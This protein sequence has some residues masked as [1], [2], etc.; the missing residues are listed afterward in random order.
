LRMGAEVTVVYRR[1]RKEMPAIET[2]IQEAQ[3]E[4][5]RF[6]F[7]TL[8][9][10]IEGQDKAEALICRRMELSDFALDGRRRPIPTDEVYTLEV[11]TV[12]MAIGQQVLADTIAQQTGIPLDRSGRIK[13]DPFTHETETAMFFAG[14]DAVTGPSIVLEAVGAGEQ[15]AVAINQSLSGDWPRAERPAPF[16]RRVIRNDVPFDPEA[17]PVERA[18][19][20]Q[21]TLPVEARHNLEEVELAIDKTVAIQEAQRC[22]RCDYRI[23]E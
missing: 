5:V 10:R 21:P 16:W 18:R 9:E 13:I 19:M 11:D 8:P 6:E 20:I 15:A 23:V 17:E 22:L 2:E 4:G 14:G 3:A 12:I 1:T 7:L